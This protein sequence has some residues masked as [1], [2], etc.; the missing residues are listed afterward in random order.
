MLEAGVVFSPSAH[1]LQCTGPGFPGPAMVKV[2]LRRLAAPD[3]YL[4]RH[5][6]RVWGGKRYKVFS[7]ASPGA[8]AA[9]ARLGYTH[10]R[11]GTQWRP[12]GTFQCRPSGGGTGMGKKG[13]AQ[14]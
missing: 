7:A 9:A 3:E 4:R 1:K 13:C 8:V 2:P 11:K 10:F 6:V 12:I 5:Q 14:A